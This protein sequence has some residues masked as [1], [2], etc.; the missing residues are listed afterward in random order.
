MGWRAWKFLQ[1]FL[2][3]GSG[4]GRRVGSASAFVFFVLVKQVKQVKLGIHLLLRERGP[5]AVRASP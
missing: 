4:P 1:A 3:S 5:A 2:V